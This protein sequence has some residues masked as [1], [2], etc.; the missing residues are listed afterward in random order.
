MTWR[1]YKK[2]IQKLCG[3]DNC[4]FMKKDGKYYQAIRVCEALTYVSNEWMWLD[5]HGKW[6]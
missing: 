3:K 1:K 6:D 2:R 5:F 4:K